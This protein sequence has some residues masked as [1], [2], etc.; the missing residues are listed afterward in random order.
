[1]LNVKNVAHAKKV[2]SKWLR[3]KAKKALLLMRHTAEKTWNNDSLFHC[4]ALSYSLIVAF[5]PLIASLSLFASKIYE[6]NITRINLFLSDKEVSTLIIKFLPY[7]TDE[8]NKSIMKL[9]DNATTVGWIGSAGLAIS[10]FLLFGTIEK[11]L[12]IP[13]G[14]RQGRPIHKQIGM[15]FVVVLLLLLTFSLYASVG[16]LLAIPDIFLLN[17]FGKITSFAM[18]VLTFAIAYKLIPA[19]KVRLKAALRGGLFAAILYE[20]F[21]VLLTMYITQ[22]FMHNKIWGSL[23]LIPIVILSLYILSLILV[24]GN[25]MTYVVQNYD[26]LINKNPRDNK[27]RS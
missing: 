21:R 20:T 11:V 5:I 25:E 19:T 7:S 27:K 17:I 1:V 8:I 6:L 13:W 4:G 22:F 16:R 26:V 15:A 23:I 3:I 18:L 14:F 9:I 24:L 10:A 2:R 12:S